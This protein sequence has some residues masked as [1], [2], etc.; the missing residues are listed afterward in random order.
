MTGRDPAAA[1]TRRGAPGRPGEAG[2][3][4]IELVIVVSLIGILAMIAIPAYQ[5]SVSKARRTDGQSALMETMARQERHYTAH[6]TY[7]TDLAVLGLS[8]ASSEG[9][10]T[11]KAEA[12]GDGG[13]LQ[14]CVQLIA[15]P[16]AAQ[17]HDGELRLNSRG[18]K[19]P[20]DRW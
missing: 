15:E 16:K 5:D 17:A 18:Q 4:L 2:F 3:T 11:L 7:T 10:Y 20:A 19:L 8:S 1:D 12:C 6:N 13:S 14:S 9:F